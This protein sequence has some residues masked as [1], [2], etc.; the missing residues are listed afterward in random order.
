MNA[1]VLVPQPGPLGAL[2]AVPAVVPLKLRV[3]SCEAPD[4]TR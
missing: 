3:V 1:P 4:A 2:V